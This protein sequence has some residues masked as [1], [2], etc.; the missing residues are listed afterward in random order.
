MTIPSTSYFPDNPP[1]P[2]DVPPRLPP[3]SQPF[4]TLRDMWDALVAWFQSPGGARVLQNA[5]IPAA[6]ILVA[7]LVAAAIARS[8]VRATVRRAERAEATSVVAGLV[9]A[10][11][12]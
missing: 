1:G 3:A 4:D 8:A 5:I 7:A 11:R 12:L 10:A 9:A 6:A 2:R